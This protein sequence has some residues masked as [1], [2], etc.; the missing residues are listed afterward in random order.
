MKPLSVIAMFGVM[1]LIS[2]A[3]GEALEYGGEDAFEP[4]KA[5]MKEVRKKLAGGGSGEGV[6]DKLKGLFEDLGREHEANTQA[7]KQ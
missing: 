6:F 4:L 1:T 7:A 2:T 5:E 3:G